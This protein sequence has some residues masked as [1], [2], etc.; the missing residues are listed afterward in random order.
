MLSATPI[1]GECLASLKK[2]VLVDVV[3]YAD[4]EQSAQSSPRLRPD[5]DCD[6]GLELEVSADCMCS[7]PTLH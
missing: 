6:T 4:T 3:V 2:D 1:I 5:L 7:R